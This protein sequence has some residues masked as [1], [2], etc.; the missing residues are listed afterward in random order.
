MCRCLCYRRIL[1]KILQQVATEQLQ[2]RDRLTLAIP[3]DELL[4]YYEARLLLD[5]LTLD[6]GLL[7][8]MSIPLASRPTVFTVYKAIVV[9]M[10]QLEKYAIQWTVETEY[11]AI[12]ED[13]REK[14]LVTRDQLGKCIGSNKYKICHESMATETSD[15][16]CLAVLYFGNV[17]DANEVCDTEAVTHP[18]EE[19]TSLGYGIWLITSTSPYFKF[20]ESYMN[21]TTTA[22]ST[23]VDGCQICLLSLSCGKKLIGPNVRIRSDL[24]TCMK[25]PPL[26]QNVTARTNGSTNQPHPNSGPA[27]PLQHTRSSEYSTAELIETGTTIPT[28]S[29]LPFRFELYCTTNCTEIYSTEAVPGETVQQLSVLENSPC[30]W[31][32]IVP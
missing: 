3:L 26:K 22:G 25:V 5:V 20:R 8:T 30:N 11:V 31:L 24:S 10:P 16:S 23:T 4:A 21:A 19:A 6:N 9:T 13:L 17:M 15:A 1:G 27:S 12:S 28:G 29:H 7:M 2:S 32:G 18:L 14:A